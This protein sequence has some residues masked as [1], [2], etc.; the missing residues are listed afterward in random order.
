MEEGAE[1]AGELPS[2][3][4]I[5]MGVDSKGGPV[6]AYPTCET[7]ALSSCSAAQWSA[8]TALESPVPGFGKAG[9]VREAAVPNRRD[10]SP[11]RRGHG[12]PVPGVDG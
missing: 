5:R 10:Q 8:R 1:G 3:A 9:G 2:W 4:P 11:S 12:D 6:V 7:D